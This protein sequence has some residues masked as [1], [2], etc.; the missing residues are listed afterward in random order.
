MPLEFTVLWSTIK[1][2]KW[3]F[4]WWKHFQLANLIS[5]W[6][7]MELVVQMRK[8]GVKPRH[9][10]KPPPLAALPHKLMVLSCVM[11]LMSRVGMVH[12]P[13]PPPATVVDVLGGVRGLFE[14]LPFPS[15]PPW[16]PPPEPPPKPP[17]RRPKRKRCPPPS[18]SQ[19]R[20][21]DE[22]ASNAPGDAQVNNP[23]KCLDKDDADEF[24]GCDFLCGSC[25]DPLFNSW[26]D[27]CTHV[28]DG[29]WNTLCCW[30]TQPTA[31]FGPLGLLADAF[32][33]TTAIVDTGASMCV[34]PFIDD[35]VHYQPEHGRVLKGLTK[36]V[37]IAG[38]G[39]VRWNVEVNGKLV[40]L[41][42][43][44]L[45]VPQSDVRL[46]SPQQLKKEHS[47]EIPLMEIKAHSVKI[48]FAEGALECLCNES[49]LPVIQLTTPG[50]HESDLK[51]LNACVM[52][53]MNQN[54]TVSQKELLKWHCRFGHLALK[55]CQRILKSGAVG[56]NP[57]IK[58]ASNVDLNKTP[59]ICGSC[60][61]SKAKRKSHRKK[62]DKES[63]TVHQPEKVLSKEVLIPGQ[64]V[65]MDHFI[66]STPGR[67]FSSRGSEPTHCMHRGGVIFKDH[68]S[69]F[70]FVEPVVNFT[71]GEAIRAK[72]AFEKEMSSMGVT[73]VHY[74]TDNGVFTAAE[75][76]D[77][78]NKSEQGLTLSGV[79]A[80]HQNAVAE[81]EIGVVFNLARTMML[82]AKLRWPKCV[83]AK[84]WPMVLKHTQ[85]LVNHIPGRNTV[86]PLDI[87]LKTTVPRD[88]LKN[89]HVWGAPS[90]VL[91][92]RLQDG[93]K[94]PKWEPRSRRGMNLGW[95]PLHASTVPLILNLTTGH[96]SPQFHVVF[97]DWFTTVSTDEKAP[98][99]DDIEDTIWS[100]LFNDQRFQVH[101]DDDDPMDLDDEWLS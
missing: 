79:G 98:E 71:A 20:E 17:K 29:W 6:H 78:L 7:R 75:F 99:D 100:E 24:F 96:I 40:E 53:E 48:Q 60:A 30:M 9:S 1:F 14:C 84:L 2:T 58:A 90:Y 11:L 86:C 73:V 88:H 54:L 62:T 13:L 18:P 23:V 45:H 59:L 63:P 36:G 50:Q 25:N 33:N 26:Q 81:R 55:D 4:T 32:D 92:P 15:P 28:S 38:V 19:A 16:K 101:F 64:R 85:H 61:F 87:I 56:L 42:L 91:D 77:E 65:S 49:N 82:H 69:S 72:R 95:S 89:L 35:F 51:A 83:S 67:L 37:T 10:P 94:I 47:P 34:S 46:L 39:V 3:L 52:S 44:A 66:V 68:A 31:S 57:V 80:H 74:H 41:K 27:L 93:Q 76:Q 21:G 97:D 22:A 70:V 8:K 43:R 5:D 12:V